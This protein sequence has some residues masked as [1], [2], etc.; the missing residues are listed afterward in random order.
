MII[1]IAKAVFTI[2]SQDSFIQLLQWFVPI[3][4]LSLALETNLLLFQYSRRITSKF[5]IHGISWI[6]LT[7][8]SVISLAIFII[9]I[10]N[11]IDQI[12]CFV[13]NLT[14]LILFALRM[15]FQIAFPQDHEQMLYSDIEEGLLTAWTQHD[16]NTLRRISEEFTQERPKILRGISGMSDKSSKK[17]EITVT[18]K[19]VI[20]KNKECHYQLNVH[21]RGKTHK[22]FRTCQEF[23]ELDELLRIRAEQT[24]VKF[25]SL[26]NFGPLSDTSVS[27]TIKNLQKYMD[28]MLSSFDRIPPIVL[29]FLGINRG[30]EAV[31]DT[32]EGRISKKKVTD[33]EKKPLMLNRGYSTPDDPLVSKRLVDSQA[34]ESLKLQDME[35]PDYRKVMNAKATTRRD[36]VYFCPY[37][38][39]ELIDAEIPLGYTH[40]EYIF[41]L[42]ISENPQERW[43]LQKRY[44]EFKQLAD[45]LRNKKL[46]P[47][48]LPPSRMINSSQI[49]EERK[50]G[51]THFLEI[52]LNE[53]IFLQC[54]EV[55]EFVGLSRQ[56][57]ALLLEN[58]DKYDYSKCWA[59]ISE[60]NLRILEDKTPVTEFIIIIHNILQAGDEA[61]DLEAGHLR[62]ENSYKLYKRMVDFEELYDALVI[63]FGRENLPNLPHKFTALFTQTS[64]ESRMRGLE[65]FLNVL[66]TIPN[67][68]DSFAFRKFL[69]A[70]AN[71]L[72]SARRK[73]R[74]EPKEE[75]EKKS[76]GE[77]DNFLQSSLGSDTDKLETIQQVRHKM[78]AL[79][80]ETSQ[81]EKEISMSI[82]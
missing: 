42:T 28:A 52:L 1:Y 54:P 13:F 18:I 79:K 69:N 50:I 55:A 56:S 45:V 62:K 35:T 2:V 19:A 4:L 23:C 5:T 20:Q 21:Y 71:D 76:S 25:V 6:S 43:Q 32:K 49:V 10:H 3:P 74:R 63:K 73:T 61:D 46:K 78:N 81:E 39:V 80:K 9:A 34:S 16:D 44:R 53:E 29:N 17:G 48:K 65:S 26:S 82:E 51:L 11:P 38:T 60:Y 33:L 31:N 70:P 30:T 47:P 64:V 7:I 14:Q 58:S 12:V 67:I 72:R 15:L 36:E 22:V 59:E 41:A 68:G 66:F 75:E 8:L 57:Q 24:N 27:E 40:Y 37:I 77:E